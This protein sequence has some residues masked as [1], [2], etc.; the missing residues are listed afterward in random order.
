MKAMF[1][2]AFLSAALLLPLSAQVWD[3]PTQRV[4]PSP[5][6]I[7]WIE[8]M[9]N[10][11]P[12]SLRLSAL[13]RIRP[14]VIDEPELR[15]GLQR[16]DGKGPMERLAFPAEL[17]P[18]TGSRQL[19][20]WQ[21]VAWAVGPRRHPALN[22]PGLLGRTYDGPPKIPQAVYVSR[23]FRTWSLYANGL[24]P[25]VDHLIPLENGDFVALA[26]REAF[27]F[28]GRKGW[29]AR[30]QRH[31]DGRMGIQELLDGER[32]PV[33]P[34]VDWRIA[35]TTRGLVITADRFGTLVLDNRQGRILHARSDWPWAAFESR[36]T[37]MLARPDGTVLVLSHGIRDLDTN[38][39][40]YW[41]KTDQ[42]SPSTRQVL[43][44]LNWGELH[45]SVG[46][47]R[48]APRRVLLGWYLLD[49]ATGS[50][51]AVPPPEGFPQDMP[52]AKEAELLPLL[53]VLPG[54][55]LAWS[56]Q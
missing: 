32:S 41:T 23:D 16:Q 39:F 21:G 24:D 14:M 28:G 51:R 6:S 49:P 45:G 29:V 38:L 52:Y 15:P 13:S 43:S 18:V 3:T 26:C 20:Y 34:N 53:N 7:S 12:S 1:R 22:F 11:V 36:P 5:P 31:A 10:T 37:L 17:I 4:I 19:T 46:M 50:S 48:R 54:G 47:A 27:A 33:R 25:R 8:R 35:R 30:F 40:R 9:W 2:S 44:L 56:F 55:G 42:A